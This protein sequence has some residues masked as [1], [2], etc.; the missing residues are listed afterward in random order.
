MKL[1]LLLFFGCVLSIKLNPERPKNLF[2]RTSLGLQMNTVVSN[3]KGFENIFEEVKDEISSIQAKDIKN[4]SP[5]EFLSHP[6]KDK[7][8]QN[9]KFNENFYSY[10]L[11]LSIGIV[12]IFGAVYF[13]KK[14]TLALNLYKL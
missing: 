11:Y 13:Y 5:S 14:K 10:S 3:P 6:N 7:S 9:T 8:W 1:I 12:C 4:N 2:F